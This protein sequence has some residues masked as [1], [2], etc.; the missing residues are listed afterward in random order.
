[1]KIIFLLLSISAMSIPGFSANRYI[2]LHGL[3]GEHGLNTWDSYSTLFSPGNG[4][5][6][7]YTSDNT[8]SGITADLYSR[9]I[10][11]LASE[12]SMV[13]IGHSMGGLIARKLMSHSDKISGI[14][15]VASAH[16]GSTLLRN[17]LNGNVI[18]YFT[19]AIKMANSA[20]DASLWSGIFSG[21]PVT[22]LA[23]PLITPVSVFRN[24]T[25]NHTLFLLKHAMQAGVGVYRLGHPCIMDMLPGS[26]FLTTLNSTAYD[27]PI[28]NI[29]GAED[30]WQVVRALG[31]LS[32]VD[33]VKDSQN[34]DKSYDDTYFSA[35]QTGLAIIYQVQHT[36]NLVYNAL[37]IVA[38]FLPWIWISRELVLKAR[39]NW[40]EM[41]RYLETGIHT[42]LASA[43]GATQYQLQNYCVPT[44]PDLNQLSCRLM[45]LPVVIE[46]DGVLSVKD[47]YCNPIPDQV[48]YNVRVAGVNHQEAGNHVAMRK[49]M[50]EII[51]L[52]LYGDAFAR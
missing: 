23:A 45:Y 22:T 38:R 26:S 13:V 51:N 18:D 15:T 46:N 47:S 16:N 36:H 17:T 3:E 7:E 10:K 29:Y 24:K 6:F 28:L 42:D 25:V 48:V 39:Y 21:I 49:L 30:H 32:Q 19:R 52:K 34:L 50:N 11:P 44:G 9:K 43:M 14:I 2:W 1:M 37:G 27:V 20:I 35:L 12:G 33:R 5:V 40:D 4:Y 8:I 31:S 41:Y